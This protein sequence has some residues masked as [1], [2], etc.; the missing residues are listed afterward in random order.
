MGPAHAGRV[1]AQACGGVSGWGLA[2]GRGELATAARRMA[3]S[4]GGA[5]RRARLAQDGAV[6]QLHDPSR[7]G[8]AARP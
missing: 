1:S 7:A 5:A 2:R 4:P 3:R 6:L 8:T